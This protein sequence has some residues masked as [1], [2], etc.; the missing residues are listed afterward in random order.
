LKRVTIIGSTGSIG[1]TSLEVLSHLRDRFSIFALSAYRNIDRLALQI[2]KFEPSYAVVAD[3]NQCLKLK[4]MVSKT[5]VLCGEEGLLEISSHPD[6]DIV[7]VATSNYRGVFPTLAGIKARKRVA[8]ATKEVLVCFGEVVMRELKRYDGELLP[9]D[10]E[11]SAI[12]QCI[13]KREKRD[14]KRIIL[15]ASGG[16]FLYEKNFKEITV[17]KALSHPVWR[18][19]KKITIDSATLMNKGL[20]VIEA[21]WLFDIEPKNI[22]VVIHP[23]SIIH[24]MVEFVD[25]S[26][27]AQLSLPDMKLAVQYAL[28]FPLRLPSLLKPL[29]LPQIKELRFLRPDREKFPCLELA[30]SAI[31]EGGS[32]PAVLNGADQKAVEL[33]LQG[34]IGFTQIPELIKRVLDTHKPILRPSLEELI[35]AVKWAYNQTQEL[36]R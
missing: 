21:K 10:S 31:R 5:K 27:L 36:I 25:G 8:L 7:I 26:L 16:P 22:D 18:M 12:H 2:K 17:D 19:G 33:F 6:T 15:T 30:Y 1:Q 23:Q 35:E 13:Y 28:T 3:S 9:I 29:D 14:I 32:Y 4:G 11:H 24:S 20:E 34:V